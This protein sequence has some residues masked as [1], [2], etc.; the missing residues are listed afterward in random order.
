MAS[1]LGLH[2]DDKSAEEPNKLGHVNDNSKARTLD[3]NLRSNL[4]HFT[5]SKSQCQRTRHNLSTSTETT[6]KLVTV[7]VG[8]DIPLPSVIVQTEAT[9]LDP[10]TAKQGF[11]KTRTWKA[12]H[13]QPRKL[14]NALH[15]PSTASQV[16]PQMA[17][18]EGSL[19]GQLARRPPV[20]TPAP[21]PRH[22][23]TLP[24]ALLSLASRVLLSSDEESR[25]WM[26][27][28]VALSMSAQK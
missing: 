3:S 18:A 6:P 11:K 24:S 4:V 17:A 21:L 19:C 23:P 9:L 15:T 2:K 22:F 27:L 10:N 13:Q 8:H 1:G 5:S 28:N 12:R 20:N 26:E 7:I 25:L 16:S 14:E